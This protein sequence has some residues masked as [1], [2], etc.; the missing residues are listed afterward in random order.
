MLKIF[1]FLITFCAIGSNNLFAQGLLPKV[2]FPSRS[3]MALSG[4]DWAKK[5][6][7]EEEKGKNTARADLKRIAASREAELVQ[8]ILS[9]NFPDFMRELAQIDVTLH[10][11]GSIVHASYW[12]MPDYLMVGNDQDFFRVPMTPMAAQLIADRLGF[13]LSTTKIADDVYRSA[14]VKLEPQ[15]LTEERESLATFVH[16][17]RLIEGQRQGRRGLI[18]GIKKDVVSTSR[19]FT[20]DRPDRL[21]LYGWHQL[22]GKPIQPLYTGHINHYVDYSHGFRLV[23]RDIKVGDQFM[24]FKEVLADPK[25][26]PILTHEDDA[27][28]FEYPTM[29]LDSDEGQ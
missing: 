9:G 13:F 12:V 28:Y 6:M 24:D 3:E 5:W 8:E 2:Q 27:R 16:H 20:T 26:R 19:L 22:D 17:H 7:A 11:D 18:A 21:A 10:V 29:A 23:W 14:A 25:L 4:S 1:L 15:P